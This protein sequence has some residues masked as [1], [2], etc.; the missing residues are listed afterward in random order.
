MIRES[1]DY[2]AAAA[3]QG[4]LEPRRLVSACEQAMRPKAGTGVPCSKRFVDGGNSDRACAC[5]LEEG[6][7]SCRSGPELWPG[8]G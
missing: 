1:P 7:P 4:E 3:Y 8:L 5:V 6:L 2:L